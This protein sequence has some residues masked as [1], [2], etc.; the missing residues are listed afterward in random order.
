MGDPA[1]IGIKD[2][3]RPKAGDRVSIKTGEVPVFWA[4]GVTPQAFVIE[5]RPDL[6][7]THKPGHMFVTDLL[8]EEIATF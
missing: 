8:N 4:R 5:A 3:K 7:I 2:L 1:A 6:C